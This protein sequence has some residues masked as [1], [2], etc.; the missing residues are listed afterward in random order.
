LKEYIFD[1]S[2]QIACV[3]FLKIE[4]GL[5]LK[6]KTLSKKGKGTDFIDYHKFID[7][8]SLTIDKDKMLTVIENKSQKQGFF[9][10]KYRD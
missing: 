4:A 5:D 1:L 2:K 8:N 6:F 10:K 7:K 9:K 3:R